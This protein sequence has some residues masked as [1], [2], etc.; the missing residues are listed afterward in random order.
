MPYS[1]CNKQTDAAGDQLL[2]SLKWFDIGYKL[3]MAVLVTAIHVFI[4]QLEIRGWPG[5]RPAMT[6][7]VGIGSS[8]LAAEGEKELISL[9]G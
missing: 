9:D 5:L 4:L 8:T 6:K 2:R 1:S 7:S 3:V